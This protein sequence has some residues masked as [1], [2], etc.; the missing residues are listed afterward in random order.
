MNSLG[1]KE[2]ELE[3]NIREEDFDC[4]SDPVCPKSRKYRTIDGS[5]NH[6]DKKL[7]NLG[8]SVS[9]YRRFLKPAYDDGK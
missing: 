9:G 6:H 1:L 4:L 2:E 7:R 3:R 5:C 8:R